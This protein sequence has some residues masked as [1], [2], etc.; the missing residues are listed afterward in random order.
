MQTRCQRRRSFY[1]HV[2]RDIELNIGNNEIYL[3]SSHIVTKIIKKYNIQKYTL[4]IYIYIYI[5]I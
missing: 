2:F 5:Y 3:D 1:R 4:Y